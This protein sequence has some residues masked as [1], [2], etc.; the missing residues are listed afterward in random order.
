MQV[1]LVITLDLG[2]DTVDVKG[3]TTNKTML[4]G[5]L[6]RAKAKVN[7]TKEAAQSPIVRVNGGSMNIPNGGRRG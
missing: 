7:E 6:E 2:S 1:Q 5:M 4:L 3:N